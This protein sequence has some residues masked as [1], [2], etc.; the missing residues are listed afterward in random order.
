MLAGTHSSTHEFLRKDLSEDVTND[1]LL[2]VAGMVGICR[3]QII[4]G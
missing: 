3:V 4:G 1:E 2:L